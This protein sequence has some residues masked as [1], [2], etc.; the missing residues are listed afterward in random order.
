MSIIRAARKTQYYV[1]PTATIEDDRL[2]WEAR[3]LLIYLLQKPD[4]WNANVKR[5]IDQTKN[6]L[7]KAAGRDKVY[8]IL[9]ELRM[10]GYVYSAFK[11]VGGEFKGVSYEVSEEPDLEAAAAYTASL[12]SGPDQPFTDLPETVKTPPPVP[13]LPETAPPGTAKP[14]ALTST[15]SSISTE[16]ALKPITPPPAAKPEQDQGADIDTTLPPDYPNEY[17]SNP[18]STIFAAWRAYALA[19]HE[20]YKQWPTYNSTVAGLMG[21][22]V[23]R[24]QGATPAAVTHYVKHEKALSVVDKFHPVTIFLKHCEAYKAKAVLSQQSKKRADKASEA[25]R[26]AERA[27][28]SVPQQSETR[29]SV[30]SPASAGAAALSVLKGIRS[31]SAK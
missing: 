12:I 24:I 6:C 4:N 7:G 19:F 21:K 14:G 8:A 31:A 27:S 22:A 2:S 11:R 29:K 5:L 25:V 13:G 20:Q 28:A 10:A 23:V 3:G 1:L 17:P 16:K 30:P 9:K 26:E 15:E 18:G